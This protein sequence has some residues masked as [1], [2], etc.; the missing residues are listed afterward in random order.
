MW[1]SGNPCVRGYL[2][3]GKNLRLPRVKFL[4]VR[5][6]AYDSRGPMKPL[7]LLLSRLNCLLKIDAKDIETARDEGSMG[8]LPRRQVS[9]ND[10]S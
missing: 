10:R 6:E 5:E 8:E 3:E 4:V 9:R 2:G 7:E 1:N